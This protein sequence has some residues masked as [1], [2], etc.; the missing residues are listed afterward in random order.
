LK[1]QQNQSSTSSQLLP[2]SMLLIAKE[3]VKKHGIHSV[4]DLVNQNEQLIYKALERSQIVPESKE[5]QL[6]K[7]MKD[8]IVRFI[9]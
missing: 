8:E 6:S 4:H 7:E 2:E 1:E 3:H 9:L 5:Q